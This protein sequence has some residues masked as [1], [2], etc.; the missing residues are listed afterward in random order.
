MLLKAAQLR[1]P[2]GW[3]RNNVHQQIDCIGARG[4][5]GFAPP[6]TRLQRRVVV[7]GLG[8]VTPLG[9]GVALNWSRLNNGEHGMVKLGK[10][11]ESFPCTVAACVPRGTGEGKF[12]A[13]RV[14][15]KASSRTQSPDY[16]SFAIAAAAEALGDAGLLEQSAAHA[17]STA[18]PASIKGPYSSERIGVAIGTGIGGIDETGATA[19]ALAGGAAAGQRKVSPFFVPRILVNMAAGNV[20][21][22]F[23]LQGPNHAVSTACATGANAI[24]DAFRMIKYGD[25]E[26][27]VAGG[28]EGCVNPI[29]IAGFSRAKA[30]ATRYNDD[31]GHASR[32]FDAD[33]DGFVLGEGAGI[34]VLE[35][36]QS[37]I[38]RG[39]RIYGEVRGYGMA[40]DANHITAPR[41][42]GSGAYRCMV[43]ALAEGGLI[44]S[45]IDYINAHATS[46]P[47]GD[48]IE[49][50]G[51]GRLL[52]SRM[53][54]QRLPASSALGEDV[55][56]VRPARRSRVAVSSTKGAIG[57][58]L[59]A[60]GSVEAIYSLLAINRGQTPPT[61]NLLKPDAA[62]PIDTCDFLSAS[63]VGSSSKLS[64][65]AA[66]S[67]SFGFGGT[68]CS[69][70]FSAP[71]A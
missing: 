71:P 17:P 53:A 16:I 36:M 62:L 48:N 38:Q 24:G 14:I 13:S 30:L 56:T 18:T 39:A 15:D 19:V 70:L 20:S 58:L 54:R 67:N 29:A 51:I 28:T 41:E 5:A 9:V 12:D 65:R 55:T 47:L 34:V 10:D 69:L 42:D 49:A 22:K 6:P 35:E 37:A 4:F 64:V 33:R 43:A 26:C 23:G 27:M 63:N 46:T 52:G 45:D 59:G 66:I 25:A 61:L 2:A 8:L 60:A 21:I 68:N 7:T 1:L 50:L 32:P 3:A 57:H 44:A 11:F 40:G 31:P